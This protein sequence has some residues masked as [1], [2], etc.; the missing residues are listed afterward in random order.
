MVQISTQQP[1]CSLSLFRNNPREINGYCDV[2]F[3]ESSD[4]PTEVVPLGNGQVSLATNETHWTVNCDKQSP[5]ILKG[6][7]FCIL[8]LNCSCSLWEIAHYIPP[9]LATCGDVHHTKII[10]ELV[11][12]MSYMKFYER[13]ETKNVTWS[14][15]DILHQI[16]EIPEIK[17]SDLESELVAHETQIQGLNLEKILELM[18]GNKPIYSSKGGQVYAETKMLRSVLISPYG[19]IA[20][21]II[22]I[23]ISA[24]VELKYSGPSAWWSY[25]TKACGRQVH[26][27]NTQ[28]SVF[29]AMCVKLNVKL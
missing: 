14:V 5:R 8:H 24:V 3:Y 25:L 26:A 21:I 2:D 11:N 13:F 4:Y 16:E 28:I 7:K 18:H 20:S 22:T 19:E 6:C 9:N 10:Q 15:E 17:F 23:I 29:W 27:G 12:A 1:R